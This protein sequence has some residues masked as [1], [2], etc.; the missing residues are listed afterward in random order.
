[1]INLFSNT[2]ETSFVNEEE[3][4][5]NYSPED[6]NVSDELDEADT[7]SESSTKKKVVNT[8]DKKS[9]DIRSNKQAISEIAQS[10][11]IYSETQRKRHQKSIKRWDRSLQVK[12]EEVRKNTLSQY[13]SWI[14]P[15]KVPQW[16]L[17]LQNQFPVK[18]VWII[19]LLGVYW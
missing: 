12:L 6:K 17:G 2:A 1:M 11:K 4:G 13:P 5:Q 15:Q 18:K 14:H 8:S 7:L 10:L 3:E 16:K 9:N 19:Y